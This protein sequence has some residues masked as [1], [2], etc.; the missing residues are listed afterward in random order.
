MRF[1]IKTAPQYTTWR[2][3]LAL[4]QAADAMEVFES[5]WNF[6]HFYPINVPDTTG[7]C[8]EAW[9]TLSALAQATKRIRIG[10]MVSGV[11]YR[12]P[13]VL[14]NMIATLDIV[15]NGRLELGLGAAWN[16]EECDAYGIHLGTL[17]ERFDR[18]DEACAIIH[19]MLTQETTTFSGKY[20][21]VTN[22]RNNPPPIQK[23]QPRW[24][25]G[26]NGETRTFPNV[27][28]YADHWNYAA[29]DLEG[30]VKKRAALHRQCRAAGRDP[31]TIMTSI[32]QPV[33]VQAL[34]DLPER[35]QAFEAAGLDLMIFY[36]PPPHTTPILDRLAAIAERAS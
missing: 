3:M 31:A 9:V 34:D 1:A 21:R 10:C 33:D 20:F 5:A 36:I 16:Q 11:V 30:F 13:A 15:S 24:C 35:I 25:I 19:G 27:V 6:D 18:F 8:M 12:H 22:A 2:D 26:G 28:K 17:K 32:H 29:F 4:W 14:A 7:P 23:P